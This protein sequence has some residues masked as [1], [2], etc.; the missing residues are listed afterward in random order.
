[1]SM[2]INKAISG[3][4][5]QNNVFMYPIAQTAEPK[6]KFKWIIPLHSINYQLYG[7]KGSFDHKNVE[8]SELIAVEGYNYPV[9]EYLVA[10][11][12]A[13]DSIVEKLN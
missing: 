11:N 1:M 9:K 5:R 10:N 3:L 4:A 8:S 7:I 12:Q 2:R 13:D 6:K